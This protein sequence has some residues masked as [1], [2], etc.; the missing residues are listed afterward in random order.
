MQLGRARLSPEE[1]RRRQL[2]GRCYYCGETGHLVAS[3]PTKKSLVVSH[4]TASSSTVRT[5]T[6]VQVKHHNDTELEALIDSG[7]D[8]S[9]MDWGLARKLG[10]KIELLERPVRASSLNGM[11]LFLITHISEPVHLHVND[12]KELLRFYLFR[13][14]SHFLVLG[15]SWLLNHNPHIDWRT[16]EIRGW[17][18]SCTQTC[19]VPLS[20][21]E[22]VTEVNLFSTNPTLEAEFPDLNTVPP[23]YH[24]L[25]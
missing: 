5:L 25:G 3:C 22:F 19:L 4:V 7:A 12:H 2:E 15:Q 10:L 20:Q 18:D 16:G 8:E 9:L 14:S 23:C 1:R 13:S 17:G 6:K 11:D 21:D 24:H